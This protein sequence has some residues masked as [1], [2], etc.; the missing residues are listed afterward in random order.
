MLQGHARKKG[1]RM[2]AELEP[3]PL[4]RCRGARVHQVI[5]NLLMN[6]IDAC[7]PEGTVTV[8]THADPGANGVSI[9]VA[10][11]GS[12]IAPE[13]RERIFDPFFTT[14]PIGEGTG[15]GLSIS[16]GIVEEHKGTI[17][18]QSTAGAGSCFTV[19]LPRQPER[20]LSRATVAA[21]E[22]G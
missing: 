15:L 8:R 18:V 6:A 19:R 11:T 17:D 16:Y 20:S 14:K 1:V 22:V 12:G 13:I 5:V 3:L 9:E 21:Q 7:E 2:T 4:V 10:D